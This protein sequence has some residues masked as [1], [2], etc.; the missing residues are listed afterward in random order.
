M[1]NPIEAQIEKFSSYSIQV[2]LWI[3]SNN[4]KHEYAIVM[5]V[6]LPV[7]VSFTDRPF[8]YLDGNITTNLIDCT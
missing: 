7:K 5:S 1:V 2:A 6:C 3:S 4:L 8:A